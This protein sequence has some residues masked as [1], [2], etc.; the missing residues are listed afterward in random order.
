[1]LNMTCLMAKN[2]RKNKKKSRKKKKMK[3]MKME[4][5]FC[6][7]DG[8]DGDHFYGCAVYACGCVCDVCDGAFCFSGN[9]FCGYACDDDDDGA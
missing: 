9:L 8:G 7:D 2:M 5:D 3:A 6:G 1:M 4:K